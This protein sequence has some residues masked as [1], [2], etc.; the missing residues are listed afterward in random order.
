MYDTD[1]L[2]SARIDSDDTDHGGGAVAELG[3]GQA[4]GLQ[5]LRHDP[6]DAV[7]LRGRLLVKTAVKLVIMV[8]RV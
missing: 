7:Q 5:A 6:E 2:G 3:V 8:T 1:R 4:E